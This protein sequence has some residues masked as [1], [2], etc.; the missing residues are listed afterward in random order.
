[1]QVF[2]ISGVPGAG[3]TTVARALAERLP[4]SAHL[5][6]DRVLEL[7]VSG[8]VLP[9]EEPQEEASR[10][11][12]VVRRNICL[13]ADSFAEAGFVPVIDD[14]IVSPGV[15]EAYRAQLATRPL[16]FV[17]LAPSLDV[18]RARDAGR[19]K[20]WFEVW[21]HLDAQMREWAPKPGL[22]LDS[23]ELTVD[24]TVDAIIANSDNGAV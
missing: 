10:Q 14:V 21:S 1:V 5:E 23:S 13:L 2:L 9:H 19:D 18:V 6:G 4:N 16:V 8:R 3:K 17:Q 24:E 22:W 20:Q 11:L 12:A 15:L 7:V